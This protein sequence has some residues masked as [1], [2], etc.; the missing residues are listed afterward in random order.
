MVRPTCCD[1]LR[2]AQLIIRSRTL[3]KIPERTP[4]G[5][6]LAERVTVGYPTELIR[7]VTANPALESGEPFRFA[8]TSG[9]SVLLQVMRVLHSYLRWRRLIPEDPNASMWFGAS[10]RKAS[11]GTFLAPPGIL[12]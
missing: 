9:G 12:G 6:A 2:A 5:L 10:W 1:G 11:V 4:E 8:F 7:A 3:G